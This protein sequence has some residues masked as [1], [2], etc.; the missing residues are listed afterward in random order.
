MIEYALML[1][2]ISLICIGAVSVVGRETLPFYG[3]VTQS[4]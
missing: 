4:L 3:P 2:L 1:A